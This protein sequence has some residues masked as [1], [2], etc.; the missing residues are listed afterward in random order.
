MIDVK[1][2]ESIDELELAIDM[3][4]DLRDQLINCEG[5]VSKGLACVE[6]LRFLQDQYKFWDDRLDELVLQ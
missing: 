3:R 2:S 4:K 5:L 1:D 6:E